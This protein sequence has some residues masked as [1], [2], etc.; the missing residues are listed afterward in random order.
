MIFLLFK[1]INIPVVTATLN[2]FDEKRWAVLNWE[3]KNLQEVS[4]VI[5]ILKN[6]L[7]YKT[8]SK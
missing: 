8:S 4:V 3:C 5:V 7:Q 1:I 2:C 6:S